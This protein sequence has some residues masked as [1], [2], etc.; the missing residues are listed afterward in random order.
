MADANGWPVQRADLFCNTLNACFFSKHFAPLVRARLVG[1]LAE[2]GARPAPTKHVCLRLRRAA[3]PRAILTL[4]MLTHQWH[5]RA[6]APT[7][8]A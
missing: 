7:P 4:V 2:V 3:L 6:E 1:A 5:L 8:A